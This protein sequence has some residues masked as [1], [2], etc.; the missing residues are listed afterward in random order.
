MKKDKLKVEETLKKDLDVLKKQKAALEEEIITG[1]KESKNKD[2][3]RMTI[4]KIFE[5]MQEL[6][7]KMNNQTLNTNTP[8]IEFVC[9][10][11]DYK[12]NNS[13]QLKQHKDDQHGRAVLY[14]CNICDKKC[15]DI[16]SLKIHKRSHVKKKY[17]CKDCRYKAE[18]GDE[19]KEHITR[20][21]SRK[22]ECELCDF[23]SHVKT[24]IDDHE[25]KDHNITKVRRTY[26]CTKCENIF[27][28]E[29]D[30]NSHVAKEHKSTHRRGGSGQ[31]VS[32]QE[33]KKN[34][35]CRF[36][37]H[38]RCTYAES[39]KF[40]HEE[41]PFCQFQERCRSKP[42]CQFFH[43]EYAQPGH[44]SSSSSFLG[45]RQFQGRGRN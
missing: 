21:H 16:D 28:R 44:Q 9:D 33:R 17:E 6:M 7:G 11:C 39:C 12:T 5:G 38:T 4:L 40:L 14:A 32:Y 22:Y 8:V 18:T 27:K 3:E 19:L 30:L 29:A 24:D 31:R 1:S 43:E 42:M 35:F 23:N 20:R 26:D 34:G 15:T 41:A 10:S 36:W 13:A 45:N 37:N 25:R 2:E